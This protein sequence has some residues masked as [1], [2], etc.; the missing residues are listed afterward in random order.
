MKGLWN[1]FISELKYIFKDQGIL[2]FLVVLPLV[3]PIVY[4]W[5]YNNEVA[6]D[7]PVCVVDKSNSAESREFIR[8]FDATQ[9]AKVVARCTSMAEAQE[10]V[11][12]QE[13]FGVLYFPSDFSRNL[14]RMEQAHLSVYCDMSLILAYK[15][16]YMSAVAIQGEMNKDIQIKVSGNQ[17]DREDEIQ[18]RPL[19]FS[20]VAM[21]NVTGGYGN[22]VIPAVL[23]LLIQQTMLLGIGMTEGTRREKKQ[24]RGGPSMVA[25]RLIAYMMIYAVSTAYLLLAV[26]HMFGFVNI[27]YPL[28]L[29]QLV[30]PYLLACFF[31]SMASMAF[32]RQR[33]DVMV[34]V[35]FTSILLLF[36]SGISWPRTALPEVFQY[37]GAFFPSTF[38]IR[39]FIRM[40]S[41]GAQVSDILQ[42]CRALWAQTVIYLAATL[43]IYRGRWS[44]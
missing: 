6:R 35:V 22:F 4:S 20:D 3:Y 7:V 11:A 21:F 16:V 38:G 28:Q 37:I 8:K 1:S 30:V 9:E 17:T 26:P 2:I 29:V 33:E 23:M 10:M 36:I 40:N 14:N 31:F 43:I 13:A 24:R 27:I 15:A 12:R 44:E 5:I 39:G 34:I 41:M 25:G 18:S 19:D 42:E 32:F